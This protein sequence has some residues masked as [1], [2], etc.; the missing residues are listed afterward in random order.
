[1]SNSIREELPWWGSLEVQNLRSMTQLSTVQFFFGYYRNL[2]FFLPRVLAQWIRLVCVRAITAFMGWATCFH[3]SGLKHSLTA[4][5]GAVDVSLFLNWV[6]CANTVEWCLSHFLRK[7]NAKVNPSDRA[8]TK[9]PCLTRISKPQH[10]L[11]LR[12][13]WR[14][15]RKSFNPFLHPKHQS[16]ASWCNN[17]APCLIYTGLWMIS[18]FL[19]CK[20]FGLDMKQ[21]SGLIAIKGC[22]VGFGHAS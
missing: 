13:I 21:V 18:S 10:L 15:Q 9:T 16:L 4:M 17:P 14:N 7:T 22:V 11:Q 12:G 6:T 2:H 1:M 5:P 19:C 20:G 8:C 3:S